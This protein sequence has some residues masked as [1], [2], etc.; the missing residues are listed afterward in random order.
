MN[1]SRGVFSPS[2]SIF[3]EWSFPIP[4]NPFYWA[5]FELFQLPD[6]EN[7]LDKSWEQDVV[8]RL[9]ASHGMSR[10]FLLCFTCEGTL[11]Q[12]DDSEDYEAAVS[13]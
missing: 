11:L 10:N 5:R 7:W 9:S 3:W 1:W 12:R 8:E 4:H 6:L 13:C 2:A